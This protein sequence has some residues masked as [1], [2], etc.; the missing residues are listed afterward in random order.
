MKSDVFKTEINYIK[1][2]RLRENLIILLNLLPDYFYEMPASTTGKYHP[3]FS[4]GQGGLV[5]HT[6]VAA[7]IAN[8]LFRNHS[9]QNFTNHEQDLLLISIILHDGL[10]CGYPKSEYTKFDHPNIMSNF[11][12]D[13]IDNLTLEDEEI[14]FIC[15]AIE[16]HMGEWTKDYNG[17]EV[18]RKPVSKYERFVHLCDY[19]S[20]QKFLDVK[21]DNDEICVN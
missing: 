11:I 6:K 9:V 13:N 1:D 17:N 14:E 10:K 5:R 4:L 16:T 8:T 3:S 2:T 20:A 7:N 21:F 19:L 15:S 18:L 12:K